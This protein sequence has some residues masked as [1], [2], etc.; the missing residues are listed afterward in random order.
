MEKQDGYRRKVMGGAV[1]TLV[2]QM[3][4]VAATI[5]SV[6]VVS[7]IL[8]PADY[9]I[10]AMAAPVTGFA[11]LFQNVGFDHAVVQSD[12]VSDVQL[13]SLFWL[14]IGLCLV[15]AIA[16]VAAGPLVSLFYG[17]TQAGILV[18]A[19]GLLV[20]ATAP[21]PLY[22]A[23]LNRQMRF[24]A[25][26]VADIVSS[27]T[28]FV[29]TVTA[30][31]IL[32]SYWALLV[33]A[34]TSTIVNTLSFLYL[35]RWRP[36]LTFQWASIAP[37]VRFGGGIS[38]YGFA[39]FITR[40]IDKVLLARFWGATT[41]GFYDRAFRLM[42]A[43]LQNFTAPLS[44][45]ILPVLA[46]TREEPQRYR[47]AYLV[48][49]QGVVT[50]AIPGV[51]AASIGSDAAVR[52]L[53]GDKWQAAGPIFSW[54]SAASVLLLINETVPWLMMSSNRSK[55]IMNWG[56]FA[57]ATVV[58]GFLIGLPWG[59]VGM[60]KACFFGELARTPILF[61]LAARGTAVRVRDLARLHIVTGLSVAAAA[62]VQGMLPT[63]MAPLPH[64]V[65]L[66]IAGYAAAIPA[67]FL[68]EPGRHL[69]A[70]ATGWVG[71]VAARRPMRRAA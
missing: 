40:N 28:M 67:Q 3:F 18:A 52:V 53:L 66:A 50:C 6:I 35:E 1:T 21:N 15:L 39:L 34:I 5:G 51:V 48:F 65:V 69:I 46:R 14:N 55:L 56:L 47:R 37:M 44:R 7:R 30:A 25:Q 16:L 20:I 58:I 8:S 13:S 59:A 2:A 60:A 49:V 61:W 27:A 29:F 43:P 38:V 54:L 11:F 42:S 63:G 31:L 24:Q 4:R 41:L 70:T 68:S 23:L 57:S 19:S 62:G 17:N 45:I 12:E 36:R 10:Y 64:V 22:N 9:G 32:R 26:N 71:K 33:G